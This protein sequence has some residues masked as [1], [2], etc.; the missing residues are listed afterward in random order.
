MHNGQ[1]LF[2]ANSIVECE[3]VFADLSSPR[4]PQRRRGWIVQRHYGPDLRLRNRDR[5]QISHADQVI[6]G[7]GQ[8]ED[9][10]DLQGSAMSYL[11]QQSDRLQPA[12]AFFDSFAFLLAD[13]VSHVPRGI[14]NQPEETQTNRRM[15]WLAEDDRSVAQGKTSRNPEGRLDL[16][17]GLCRL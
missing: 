3:S 12:K 16:Q 9:P 13:C 15:L 11:A 17:P 14:H 7:T 10:I 1:I 6:G 5:H 2:R 8:A 4:G